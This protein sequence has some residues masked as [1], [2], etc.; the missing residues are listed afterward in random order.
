M[1]DQVCLISK[2]WNSAG[3]VRDKMIKDTIAKD[4]LKN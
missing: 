3:I 2:G 4:E 1:A